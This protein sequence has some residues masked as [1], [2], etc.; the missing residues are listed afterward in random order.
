MRAPWVIS[1]TPSEST[2]SEPASPPGPLPFTGMLELST[3]IARCI[4]V[5]FIVV[6]A[7]LAF[8]DGQQT[9]IFPFELLAFFAVSTA[10][11]WITRSA[12][13][14]LPLA[15]TLIVL[16]LLAVTESVMS[17]GVS[18]AGAGPF[19]QWHL[20]AITLVLLILAVRGQPGIAW[21]GYA[22]LFVATVLW[23]VANGL[24]AGDGVGLVIRHSGT[25]LA[26]TLAAVGLRRSTTTLARF[27]HQW[28]VNAAVEAIEMASI[29]ERQAQLA[30]LNALARPALE[31]LAVVHELTDD[32]RAHC[33]LVEATLRDAI[34]ARSLFIEPVVSAARA[35]RERGVEVTLLDDSGDQ[36][37]ADLPMVAQVLA[38]QLDAVTSGRLTA[39]LLPADRPVLATVV[40]ESTESRM[41]ALTPA[42]TLRDA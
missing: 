20:G 31:R 6:H 35:A 42:G 22:V 29:E 36:P 39:R 37:P 26:G 14:P 12:R 30:R 21:A 9:A 32:E 3:P 4:L 11:V 16:S 13:D 27:N 18:A 38:T 5:L 2:S 1:T 40:I 8:G 10:A 7:V 23:A 34:R 17:F 24:T 33:M 41:L 28:S 15:T 19:A 25:L